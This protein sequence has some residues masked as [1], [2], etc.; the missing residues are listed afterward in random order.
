[1]GQSID[2]FEYFSA[3]EGGFLDIWSFDAIIHALKKKAVKA[4]NY[5][6]YRKRKGK[7]L[8]S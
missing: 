5:Y 1:M 4:C 3:S 2:L 6:V 7:K 8:P